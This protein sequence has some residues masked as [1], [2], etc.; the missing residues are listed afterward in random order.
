[1][2]MK[3]EH[4]VPLHEEGVSIAKILLLT[5]VIATF[6]VTFFFVQDRIIASNERTTCSFFRTQPQAQ[7]TYEGDTEKYKRL[8]FD[9]DGK[10][11]ESLPQR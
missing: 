3:V 7:K 9:R 1:M 8:D 6:A 11:C 5:I 2:K 10:A 4:E